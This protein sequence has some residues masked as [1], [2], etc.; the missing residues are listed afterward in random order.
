MDIKSLQE[1]MGHSDINVTMNIYN[2][3]AGDR[4]KK[5]IEEAEKKSS[6]I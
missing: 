5:E 6:I 2:H 3:V 4:L 1:F